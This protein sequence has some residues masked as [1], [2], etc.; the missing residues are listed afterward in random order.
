M[1]ELLFITQ[2]LRRIERMLLQHTLLN[3]EVLNS[4]EAAI[5]LGL[6]RDYVG[7]LARK[8]KFPAFRPNNGRLYF[9]RMDL[10]NWMLSRALKPLSKKEMEQEKL[11]ILH[12]EGG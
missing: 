3:K 5:Y 11:N 9:K 4:K 8:G 1:S 6:S 12:A 2:Q 7:R 10:Y